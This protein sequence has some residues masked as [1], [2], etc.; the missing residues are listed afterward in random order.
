[1]L[2]NDI[3]DRFKALTS[4]YITGELANGI[5]VV[6]LARALLYWNSRSSEHSKTKK[7]T[8]I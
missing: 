1:M 2:N 5:E 7:E 8:K 6:I 4:Y 3:I